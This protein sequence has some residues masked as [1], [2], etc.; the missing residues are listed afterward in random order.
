[1]LYNKHAGGFLAFALAVG[2]YYLF[3]VSNL[4]LAPFGS[5][6]WYYGTIIVSV[7]YLGMLMYAL[8]HL[9]FA[10]V[11]FILTSRLMERKMNI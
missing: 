9:I 5:M 4:L 1:M 10:A 2:I 3:T 11:M 8:L 7:G 6:S